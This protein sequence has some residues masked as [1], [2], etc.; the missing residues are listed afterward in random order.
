MNWTF[1]NG[2]LDIGFDFSVRGF[3][4]G[5]SFWLGELTLQGSI[6]LPFVLVTVSY[7]R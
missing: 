1:L 5:V 6:E 4:L 2:R 3:G 7:A